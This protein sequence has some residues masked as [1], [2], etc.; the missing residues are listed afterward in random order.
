MLGH[1][2]RFVAIALAFSI[3]TSLANRTA[4]AQPAP[5]PTNGPLRVHPENPRYFADRSGRVV[6]LVGSHTWANFQNLTYDNAPSPPPFD[7]KAYL[8]FMKARNHNFFRL[9]TWESSFNPD[10]LQGPTRYDPMPYERPGP[11]MAT[12]GKPKYDVTKFNQAY[13]DRMRAEVI[14]ARDNGI[15]ASM[16]LFQGFSI[17]GKGNVGG[18][19]WKGHPLY[20]PNNINGVDRGEGGPASGHSLANPAIV[21]LQEAWVKKVIETVNDLDNVLYEI[22]N[23]DSGGEANTAWQY[24]MIKFIQQQEAGMKQQ[25]PVG[26]TVQYPKGEDETILLRSPATWISPHSKVFTN[27]GTKVVLN[28]TDHSYFWIGLKKDGVDAQRAWVWKNFTAGNQCQFM[29]PYLDPSHDP[30]RNSPDGTKVDPYWE[31]LRAAMGLSHTFATRMNLA[32]AV[33]HPELSSTKFCLADPGKEYFVYL[34]EGGEA[35]VDLS[36]A[37]GMLP[38]EWTH[39]TEARAVKGDAVAGGAKRTFKAPFAGDAIL[40]IGG[41]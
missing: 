6:F 3:G 21:A 13:F 34:P 22:I 25:H 15:Y 4:I 38:V 37:T 23:E 29:D 32:R 26:M 2:T 39:P 12:D 33:P 31:P 11:G 24:H 8:A 14:A 7:L 19:P 16:M 30:G 18:S 36:G 5:S 1:A 10:P 17:S 27:D 35:V 40:Y 9:W 20:G 41:K 28:D